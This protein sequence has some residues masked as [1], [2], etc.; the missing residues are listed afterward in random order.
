[1]TIINNNLIPKEV[2]VSFDD[3]I[4]KPFE[5]QGTM[6]DLVER[7][8]IPGREMFRSNQEEWISRPEQTTSYTGL[9]ITNVASGTTRLVVP[10][11]LDTETGVKPLTLGEREL[12]DK[13]YYI[14][15]WLRS[16]KQ[17]MKSVVNA[18]V[19][20]TAGYFG[21]QVIKRT[22]AV[23]GSSDFGAADVRLTNLGVDTSERLALLPPSIYQ[24][25]LNTT[26]NK[27][28]SS[29]SYYAKAFQGR[30][31]GV[32]SN[33]DVFRADT[34]FPLAAA[35]PTGVTISAANQYWIPA[36]SVGVTVAGKTKPMNIDSRIQ[37]LS[38]AKAGGGAIKV[39]DAFVIAGVNAIHPITKEDTTE[40]RTFRVTR[41]VSGTLTANG[42]G[43]GVV[44]ITP[45]I[46]SRTVAGG[47]NVAE[48]SYRNVTATPA[49]GALVTFLNTTN[50]VLCPFFHKS[51]IKFIPGKQFS[52]G[53]LNEVIGTATNGLSFK[54]S[55][56]RDINTY[57]TTYR[58]DC[59][60]GVSVVNPDAAGII[61]FNQS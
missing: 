27:Q 60:F 14:D 30:T 32:M 46:I 12:A 7:L 48:E 45:P 58:I 39:G 51:A 38:I 22:G 29:S 2:R 18:A 57:I 53:M 4:I 15:S 13:E 21:N 40:Q 10:V 25:I 33:F 8:D 52:S 47:G 5:D 34:S 20:K 44:E 6:L 23:T 56:D 41:V 61:L 9:D 26:T 59:W 28:D 16:A 43:S 54:M 3:N 19:F 36:S 42:V 31:L 37:Q 17:T 11:N 50:T 24:D 49:N 55:A 1:M 35:A